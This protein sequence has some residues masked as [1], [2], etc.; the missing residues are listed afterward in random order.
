MFMTLFLNLHKLNKLNLFL[1]F[2][3]DLKVLI[4]IKGL[5]YVKLED[6]KSLNEALKD[7]ER[8]HMDRTIKIV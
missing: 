4:F 8:T 2:N 1:T 5:A 6:E 3:K 7:I